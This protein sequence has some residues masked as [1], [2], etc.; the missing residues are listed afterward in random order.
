MLKGNEDA[1]IGEY[2]DLRPDELKSK[3]ASNPTRFIPMA[4]H[5]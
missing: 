1:L 3:A 4:L 2:Q 5:L